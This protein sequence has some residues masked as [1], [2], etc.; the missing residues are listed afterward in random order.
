[1]EQADIHEEEEEKRQEWTAIAEAQYN[2]N[3]PLNSASKK[4]RKNGPHISALWAGLEEQDQ[5]IQYSLQDSKNLDEYL[6]L[7]SQQ[8]ASMQLVDNL[9]SGGYKHH[10][11]PIELPIQEPSYLNDHLQ[12]PWAALEA[13][14]RKNEQQLKRNPNMR[15]LQLAAEGR[16]RSQLRGAMKQTPNSRRKR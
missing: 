5:R 12:E 9:M 14:D 8:D 10:G 3:H 6:R 11:K 7:S 4:E 15:M 13:Q 2:R 16:A 1:M